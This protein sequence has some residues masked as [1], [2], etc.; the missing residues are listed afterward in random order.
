MSEMRTKMARDWDESRCGRQRNAIILST[1]GQE[2]NFHI[3][4]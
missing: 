4:Q 2:G 3:F 1:I